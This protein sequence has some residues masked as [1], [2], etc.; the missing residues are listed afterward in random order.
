MLI[1]SIAKFQFVD[2]K[3]MLTNSYVLFFEEVYKRLYQ[4][5][6]MNEHVKVVLVEKYTILS[7]FV[8]GQFF[9]K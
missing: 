9:Y 2:L 4:K 5:K 7:N 1:P 8:Y 6:L 3:Q